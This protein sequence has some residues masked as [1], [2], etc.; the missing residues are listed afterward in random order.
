MGLKH[1]EIFWNH[2]LLLLSYF[3]VYF[4][5][6]T[7][8]K[9]NCLDCVRMCL[10]L[11]KVGSGT[12]SRS[13]N[14]VVFRCPKKQLYLWERK[15]HS[16]FA[17][18]PWE[19]D[20]S[21]AGRAA[22]GHSIL[23]T[24]GLRIVEQHTW[25]ATHLESVLHL[26]NPRQA[27]PCQQVSAGNVLPQFNAIHYKHQSVKWS[28]VKEIVQAGKFQEVFEIQKGWVA[29]VLPFPLRFLLRPFGLDPR[30]VPCFGV[31]SSE[32]PDAHRFAFEHLGC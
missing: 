20:A 28:L 26:Y 11:L 8:D 31:S 27:K 1:R 29:L 23:G 22:S 3:L 21:T 12:D 5:K 2:Q 9:N 4:M 16:F 10:L 19:F 6:R 14:K 7:W 17:K 25:R 13:C 30:R 32:A 15:H 24:F 18:I